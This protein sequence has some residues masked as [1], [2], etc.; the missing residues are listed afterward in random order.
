MPMHLSRFTSFCPPIFWFAHPIFLTSLRQCFRSTLFDPNTAF[1]RPVLLGLHVYLP[2][3]HALS[4]SSVS[5]P[6]L[7]P[8]PFL[9][10]DTFYPPYLSRHDP[11]YYLPCHTLYFFLHHPPLLLY[12][13]LV[14]PCLPLP[15]LFLICRLS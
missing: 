15:M 9:L 3:H 14:Y 7:V 4:R 13:L 1:I 2:V 10:S 5:H 12:I 11:G 8:F 6:L